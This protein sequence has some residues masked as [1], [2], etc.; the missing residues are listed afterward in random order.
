MGSANVAGTKGVPRVEREQQILDAAIVEFGRRGYAGASIAEIASQAG[1]SKPLIYGYFGSKEGLYIACVQR[2]GAR[3]VTAIERVLGSA[4][5]TM[6]MAEETLRAVFTV[7]QTQP[8]AWNVVYDRSVPDNSEAKIAAEYVVDCIHGQA[9][10]GVSAILTARGFT[11]PLDMS[12]LAAVWASTVT[13]LVNWWLVHPEQT[14]EQ[15]TKR[16]ARILAAIGA[17]H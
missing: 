12:A 3:L 6:K 15:M 8:L 2:T 14:A 4:D 13:A 1:I 11:D 17:P 5:P 9:V 7:L 10:R 16:S